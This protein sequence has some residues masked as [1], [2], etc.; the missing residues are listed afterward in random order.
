[1]WSVIN[2]SVC[3][4]YDAIVSNCTVLLRINVHACADGISLADGQSPMQRKSKGL[5][6]GLLC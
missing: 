4:K 1:M 5:A 6:L 3:F 2:V